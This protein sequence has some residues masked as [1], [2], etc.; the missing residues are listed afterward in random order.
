[1][2]GRK[3]GGIKS[4]SFKN[5]KLF[6][7]IEGPNNQGRKKSKKIKKETNEKNKERRKEERK[8]EKKEKENK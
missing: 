6:L 1:M 4:K 8:K 5:Y 2:E 7:S 3:E